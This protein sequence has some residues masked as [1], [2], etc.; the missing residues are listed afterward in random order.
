MCVYIWAEIPL[1]Y[2]YI[3]SHNPAANKENKTT[4]SEKKKLVLQQITMLGPKDHLDS[5]YTHYDQKSNLLYA[6]KKN[7]IKCLIGVPCQAS[8]M[9]PVCVL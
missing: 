7:I 9:K 8:L 6:Y 2:F 5:S 3:K 4:S 1:L